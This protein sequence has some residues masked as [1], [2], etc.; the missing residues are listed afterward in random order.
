MPTSLAF[1]ASMDARS[2]AAPGVLPCPITIGA[3]GAN[4]ATD[5]Y[6]W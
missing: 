3:S 2:S 1:K 4:S 6:T 5:S